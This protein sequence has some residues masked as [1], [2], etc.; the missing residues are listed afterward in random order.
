LTTRLNIPTQKLKPVP[1][2]KLIVLHSG[3]NIRH[4]LHPFLFPTPPST[5]HTAPGSRREV[6]PWCVRGNQAT[7]SPAV[8]DM[9]PG[10]KRNETATMCKKHAVQ[11]YCLKI[12]LQELCTCAFCFALW[13]FYPRRKIAYDKNRVGNG[14]E[15]KANLDV[16]TKRKAS[17][18]QESKPDHTFVI[19][20]RG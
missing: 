6:L 13:S 4:L 15:P 7:A 20:W 14:I 16:L 9:H 8:T 18:C 17:N 5:A 10:S 3:C 2:Q 1:P 12:M 19:S 11:A